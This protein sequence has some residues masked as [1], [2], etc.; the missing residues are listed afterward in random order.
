MTDDATATIH[1]LFTDHF[2]RVRELVQDLTS[3]LDERTGTFR[4]D[5][6]ANTIDWLVWHLSRVQ[7]NHI[8]GI[9]AIEQIWTS[10]GWNERFGLPF[11]PEAHGFGQSSEEVAQ[12]RVLADLLDGYHAAVHQAT[13]D[14][15]DSVTPDELNRVVDA[16]WDP[17]VTVGTRL[18]SVLG[19][20]L[21]HAGQ[22]AYVR[23][24]AERAT[25]R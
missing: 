25:G 11:A 12:V 3:G 2:G 9:A 6:E 14:Y 16:H 23:G 13:L 24:L 19:D 7:D 5:P 20:C 22:A 15:L 4:P 18:V 17:P 1:G 21:Q 10:Q 8:A